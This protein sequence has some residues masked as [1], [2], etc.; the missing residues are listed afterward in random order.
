MIIKKRDIKLF[1]ILKS[2]IA[3][4]Y[5][6]LIG[7]VYK[8][9]SSLINRVKVLEKNYY[10]ITRKING[11]KYIQLNKNGIEV[12]GLDYQNYSSYKNLYSRKYKKNRLIDFFIIYEFKKK[13]NKEVYV[14]NISKVDLDLGLN[15]N[16]K[17]LHSFK[18]GF[19]DHLILE[20][21]EEIKVAIV[22]NLNILTNKE[23]IRN[24]FDKIYYY[25]NNIPIVLI[26]F[27]EEFSEERKKVYEEVLFKMK[28]D[29][30]L[31]FVEVN[32]KI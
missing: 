29:I 23:K 7:D 21:N 1:N 30:N 32:I 16:D 17:Y 19:K 31:S 20:K 24:K 28:N 22:D 25:F 4:M 5:K 12:L 15:I 26:L 13:H 18:L 8:N 11:N 14:N 6:Q 10:I 3:V 9:Y 27:N 2:N